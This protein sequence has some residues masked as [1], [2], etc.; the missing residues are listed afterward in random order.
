M[1]RPRYMWL[2][3]FLLCFRSISA[4]PLRGQCVR[5]HRSGDSF[6]PPPLHRPQRRHQCLLLP[7]GCL[8]PLGEALYRTPLLSPAAAGCGGSVGVRDAPTL[9]SAE[10]SRNPWQTPAQRSWPPPSLSPPGEA[11]GKAL[12]SPK[13]VPAIFLLTPDLL[14][15]LR[16]CT[17]AA[18]PPAWPPPPQAPW[19]FFLPLFP[20]RPSLWNCAMEH[21][22]S[23][24]P[25]PLAL[26]LGLSFV[27]AFKERNHC[28]AEPAD[29]PR[30][31]RDRAAGAGKKGT[32]GASCMEGKG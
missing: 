20:L 32:F 15:L 1:P 19:V 7:W 9:C 5:A 21:I 14:C 26:A 30:L 31:L 18:S 3:K 25:G 16:A 4:G 13:T 2:E 23:A 6:Q 11:S 28:C 8:F 17:S 22:V 27:S 24:Q 29:Q 10:T 12:F